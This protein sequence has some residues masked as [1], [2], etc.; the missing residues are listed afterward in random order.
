ML[1]FSSSVYSQTATDTLSKAKYVYCHLSMTTLYAT[2]KGQMEIDFGQDKSFAPDAKYI[3]IVK[4]KIKTYSSTVD[5]LNYMATKGWEMD[6][7][8]VFTDNGYH[9]FQW[10]LKKKIQ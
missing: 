1:G 10:L 6:Q 4:R 5:A 3:D 8:T 7:A 9:Y 2:P